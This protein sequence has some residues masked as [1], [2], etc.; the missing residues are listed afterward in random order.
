[1]SAAE[2]DFQ[3]TWPLRRLLSLRTNQYGDLYA[4]VYPSGRKV[5]QVI[6]TIA[7]ASGKLSDSRLV[8]K[9]HEDC[10]WIGSTAFDVSAAEAKQIRERFEPLGLRVETEPLQPSVI[11]STV[12]KNAEPLVQS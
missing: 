8:E 11:H 5:G 3:G 10:L 12:D 7:W 6:K 4:A 9:P 2:L 1:M